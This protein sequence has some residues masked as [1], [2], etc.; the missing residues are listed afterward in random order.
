M[1]VEAQFRAVCCDLVYDVGRSTGEVRLKVT[2]ASMLPAV[3]P[4]DVVTVRHCGV[5]EFQPGQIIL[6]RRAGK[7]TLHRVARVVGDQVIARGTRSLAM[8]PP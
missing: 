8:T 4:G 5:A 7:L 1:N 6:Y 2:G 3:W